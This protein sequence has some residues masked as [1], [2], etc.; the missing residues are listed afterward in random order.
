M[1]NGTVRLLFVVAVC[2]ACSAALSAIVVA[3]GV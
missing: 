2:T 3:I 1:L